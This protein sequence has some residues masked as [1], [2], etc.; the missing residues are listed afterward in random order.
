M[1]DFDIFDPLKNEC[2][3]KATD[4]LGGCEGVILVVAGVTHLCEEVC[5]R[6]G[7]DADKSK[8]EASWNV[9][10]VPLRIEKMY[11]TMR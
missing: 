10:E 11:M 4:G 7:F 1:E 2:G 9:C 8:I 5:G 6:N 3:R